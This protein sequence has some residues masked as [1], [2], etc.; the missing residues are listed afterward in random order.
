MHDRP[1]SRHAVAARLEELLAGDEVLARRLEAV[2]RFAG[3]VRASE[4]HVTNACNIRCKGCWFYEYGHDK[5]AGEAKSLD[6]WKAFIESQRRQNI[7]A[8]LLIG[9][10]PALFPDR[11]AAFVEGMRYVS[12]STN[13]LRAL[14]R[15]AP[16]ENVT[17]FISVFGGGPLDDELRAIKPNGRTF[18]GLFDTA[19]ANY[20]DDPR[21]CFVYAVTERGL[22]HIEST[23]RRIRDN[24]N[25]VTFNFYSEY[26]T[27][28]PLRIHNQRL[29]LAEMLRVR[30]A[31]P[32]VVLN[33]P[34]HIEAMVTGKSWFGTFGRET[35]PSISVDHPENQARVMTG[36]PVLPMFNTWKADLKTLERCCTSG[37][38]EGCRDSQAV[39]SWFLVSMAKS[40][41]SKE[42]LSNWIDVAEGYW[43]QFIWSPYRR[44]PASPAA[45]TSPERQAALS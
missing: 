25:T 24:G 10:E 35:C 41:E 9:G 19:L 4:Y 5:T 44:M 43:R 20:K 12:I 8:A 42:S 36:E 11:V 40:L 26:N 23:V 3:S 45:Q 22:G 37:H 15:E 7:T 34:A 6:D 1:T 32:D 31:Y 13:G 2:R 27:G 17:V 29:L 38:C 30:A 33:H 39:Y 14:P 21:A 16:F 18:S 28:H